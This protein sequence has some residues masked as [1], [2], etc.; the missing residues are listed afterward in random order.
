MKAMELAVA[1]EDGWRSV[2]GA[3]N[4]IPTLSGRRGFGG[5]LTDLAQHPAQHQLPLAGLSRCAYLK[6]TRRTPF[7]AKPI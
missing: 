6:R 2:N 1:Q 3:H 4:P 7:Q 5:T